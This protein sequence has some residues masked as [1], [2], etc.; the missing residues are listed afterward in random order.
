LSNHR[1]QRKKGALDMAWHKFTWFLVLSLSLSGAF[2]CA[3][4]ISKQL[5]QEASKEV[6]FPMV[7]QNPTAY[8]GVIVLWG[9]EIIETASV[10]GGSEIIVLETPLDYQ[11]MPESERYSRGRFIAKSSKFL[12]PAIYKKEE[13]IT[14][15]GEIIG[16]QARPLGDTEY[17]YPVVMIKQLH[18]WRKKRPYPLPYYRWA[19]YWY[20]PYGWPYG[21]FWYDPWYGPW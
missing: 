11:E 10:R 14:L 16:K 9:G 18:L 3:Y 17:T 20:G 13:R 6:T 7:L 21:P 5:R 19:P 4:P 1:K 12:D 8:V 2:G 15:A